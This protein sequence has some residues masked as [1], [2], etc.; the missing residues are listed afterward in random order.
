MAMLYDDTLE[1]PSKESSKKI[2]KRAGNCKQP[3]AWA[4]E[5][6]DEV[7]DVG[8]KRMRLCPVTACDD[9]ELR[10]DSD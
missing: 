7:V 10:S 5:H 3:S 1:F 2:A 8:T 6:E 4:P 9:M